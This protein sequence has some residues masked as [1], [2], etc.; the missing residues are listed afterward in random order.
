M[1]VSIRP[2]SVVV[3]RVLPV[4]SALF[5]VHINAKAAVVARRPMPLVPSASSASRVRSL[6]MMVNANNAL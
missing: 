6:L 5:L 1:L 2:E 4:P 3:N